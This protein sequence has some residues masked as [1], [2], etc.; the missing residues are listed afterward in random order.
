MTGKPAISV[1]GAG[2]IGLWQALLLARAG[3]SVA[4]IDRSADPLAT[5][6]SRH[7]GAMLAPDCE[8]ESAPEIVRTLGHHGL[9][10]WQAEYPDIVNLGTLVVAAAR[11]QMELVRFA[12][13]T[14]GSQALDGSGLAKLEPDLNGRFQSA[15][16]FANEAHV[17]TPD[18]LS[19][20]LAQ[21]QVLGVETRFGAAAANAYEG[22]AS[23]ALIVDCRGMGARDDLTNLR[24]VRGERLLV[25]TR[26]IALTRPVRL[27]HPRHPLYVVPWG[28]GR[29]LIGA[30]MIE[31]ED[32][33]PITVRS[34]LEL[35]GAAYALHPAFGEAQVLQMDAGVRPA[36]PDNVP[37]ILVRDGGRYMS[38]NGAY[39]HGFLLA[40]VL[41][42]AVVN[43]RDHGTSHPLIDLESADAV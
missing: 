26:D 36:F 32:D 17:A 23:D 24:G 43:Y 22:R 28:D 10:L 31:S 13:L 1:L 41:A 2:I 35:L 37:R 8:A 3:Y 19:F 40:P 20:L 11:D 25:Q 7:A 18:A 39:R 27:L 21:A 42:E 16:W 6:A 5:S 4:L 12:D 33:G 15:L 14:K 9:K 29:Y 30:T 38:V 34:A